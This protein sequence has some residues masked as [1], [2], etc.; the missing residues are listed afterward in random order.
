[1]FMGGGIIPGDGGAALAKASLPG[2]GGNCGDGPI[3]RLAVGAIAPNSP[4]GALDE[5]GVSV[6]D[7]HGGIH[8]AEGSPNI[9]VLIGMEART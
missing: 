9:Y 5:Y 4:P 8:A 3:G 7:A 6:C 2:M 1:M